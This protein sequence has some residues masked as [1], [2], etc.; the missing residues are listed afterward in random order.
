MRN[1]IKHNPVARVLPQARLSLGL[2]GR[3]ALS[4][5]GNV[6]SGA[7]F[8]RIQIH[9][10]PTR[11]F[12]SLLSLSMSFTT[13]RVG[14]KLQPLVFAIRQQEF[15]EDMCAGPAFV[16]IDTDLGL[17]VSLP[18]WFAVRAGQ[19]APKKKKGLMQAQRRTRCH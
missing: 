7:L 11:S 4:G 10:V 12:R 1:L 13:G 6:E 15:R 14:V 3:P 18:G 16:A 19:S 17:L 2:I 9:V 8:G 5:G